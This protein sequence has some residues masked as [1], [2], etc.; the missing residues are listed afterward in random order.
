MVIAV[1][2]YGRGI[3]AAQHAAVFAPYFRATN[4]AADLGG[5]Q[6]LGLFISKAIVDRHAGTLGLVS[7]EGAG[8]TFTL[9][10]PLLPAPG[11]SGVAG[12]LVAAGQEHRQ[13]WAVVIAKERGVNHAADC[14][15]NHHR[16]R[17]C[18]PHLPRRARHRVVAPRRGRGSRCR[19]PR[20]PVFDE[21]LMTTAIIIT[22]R[23][24]GLAGG[25]ACAGWIVTAPPPASGERPRGRSSAALSTGGA[26]LVLAAKSIRVALHRSRVGVMEATQDGAGPNAAIRRRTRQSFPKGGRDLLR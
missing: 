21:R 5:S 16:H 20:T 3:P 25:R 2:D 23:G 4:A 1:T 13:R 19:P 22:L 11:G 15:R 7:V 6:G 17:R 12:S 18:A 9:A 26:G 10:L 8:S 24:V 14:D